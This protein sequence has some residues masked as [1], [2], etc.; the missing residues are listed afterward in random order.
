MSFSSS[1]LCCSSC[2][3]KLRQFFP[4][5]FW[6][7]VKSLTIIAGPVVL[8]NLLVFLLGVVSSIFC[9]HLGT[10]QLDAVMLATFVIMTCGVSVGTG[11][12]L[13]CDTLISQTYGS[14]NLK[15][16][17][18]ILQR[19]ILILFLFCFPCWALFINTEQL[20]LAVKQEPEVARL[21]QTYVNIFIPALPAAF[22]YQLL[23]K[24]LQNQAIVMPQVYTGIAANLLNALMNYIFLFV[25]DLDVPGSAWAN[26]IS[27]FTQTI[28]LFLYI[29]WKKLYVE[30]WG[31]WTRDCLQ[32]W[33]S[34]INLAIP[35]LLMLCVEWWAYE[36][37][38]L[39]AGLIS[40][41][42]LGAQSILYL[43]S[44]ALY[45]IPLGIGVAVSVR[46]G[47]A[48]G[49]RKTEQARASS[50]T[51]LICGVC[52]AVTLAA[53]SAGL[54]DVIGY[55][56]TTEKGIIELAAK[57]VPIF[58]FLHVFDATA[59]ICSGILRGVGKQKIGAIINLIAFYGIG[60]PIGVALMFAA[61]LGIR[62]L[63]T[64]LLICVVV[65]STLF[66]I[67]IMRLNWNAATEQAQVRA[68]V[69]A[70]AIS[71][72]DSSYGTCE[73]QGYRLPQ[74]ES[75]A[76]EGG[77]IVFDVYSG[78]S[79]SDTAELTEDSATRVAVTTVGEVLSVKQLIIRRG[80]ALL[81]GLVVLALGIVIHVTLS[82][83]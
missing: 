55:I 32:E 15:R 10:V 56:F 75:A 72:A 74:V 26:T 58:A 25:L 41:V 33:G 17:G 2:L 24:Y 43:F 30:T 68:G 73:I 28:L 39:L 80:S 66:I 4:I 49:A 13:A 69:K 9:G 38:S 40:K 16:V 31:G 70:Q 52:V 79:H 1:Y 6:A 44:S 65:Q 59:G 29:W 12:S 63:W 53:I 61:K 71:D 37:G 34:F 8:T 47:N 5:N 57:I 21:S 42:E 60:I 83:G 18:T 7:E 82:P 50:K 67:L 62:G 48:L 78:K 22:L 81:A 11:L 3:R 64:G 20:L 51:T 77:I 76:P 36:I 54:K 27:Q 35:S 14:K 45:K 46:I 23:S 19:G